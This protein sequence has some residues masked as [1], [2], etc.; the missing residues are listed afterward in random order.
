MHGAKALKLYLFMIKDLVK[1]MR[2]RGWTKNLLVFGALF[3]VPGAIMQSEAVT[4]SLLTFVG[5]C[6]LAGGLYIVNDITDVKRDR[7][8]PVKKNRPIA[9]GR[10]PT[11][12]ALTFALFLY[13]FSFAI[14]AWLDNA[15]FVVSGFEKV[16]HVDY[17]VTKSFFAYFILTI[18]YT[19]FLKR[20]SI[21]DVIIIAIGFVLRA[22]AGA[23]ALNVEISPWLL[24]CTFLLSLYLALAKRRGEL[25]QLGKNSVNHRENLAD[26]T[27]VEIDQFLGITA[28]TNIIS[29]S[30]YTFIADNAQGSYLMVTIP[31]VIFGIFR[32]QSLVRKGE[33]ANPEEILLKDRPI[34]IDL[35]IWVI[36]VVLIFKFS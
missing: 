30:L 26:Y 6:L 33:G 32:Y 29:Y 23:A 24:L 20:I 12:I 4:R 36:A 3:F 8:H 2:Y 22:V 27:I 1:S 25:V 18:L 19:T 13:L 17:S 28:A 7:N 31:M 35:L 34:Q 16:M 21:L 11:V 9:A 15:P 10:I 14:S 5:F